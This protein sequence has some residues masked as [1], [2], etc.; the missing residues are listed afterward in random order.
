MG[1]LM[2]ATRRPPQRQAWIEFSFLK[3][4][5]CTIEARLRIPAGQSLWIIEK[6]LGGFR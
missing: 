4:M 1:A 3:D 6:Y 2:T 5:N